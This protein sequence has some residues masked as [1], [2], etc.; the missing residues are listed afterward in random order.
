LDCVGNVLWIIVTG[1][2]EKKERKT[3]LRL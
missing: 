2:D 3:H 1:F